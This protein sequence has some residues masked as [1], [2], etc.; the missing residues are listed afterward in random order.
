M[1]ARTPQLKDAARKAVFANAKAAECSSVVA[2][3]IADLSKS[4]GWISR[5]AEECGIEKPR[6]S[7][8]LQ[9]KRVVSDRMA[10]RIA[11]IK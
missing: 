8:L 9:G 2:D 4:R 6:L 3:M 11:G 7:E 10:R 1:S 5:L